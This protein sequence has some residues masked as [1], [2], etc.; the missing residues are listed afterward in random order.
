M[1]I[2]H[3]RGRRDYNVPRNRYHHW[4]YVW[5]PLATA[6]VWFGT[7]LALLITWLASGRPHYVSMSD[8]QT[9]AYISD[10]AADFLKPLFITGCAITAIGFVFCLAVERWARHEGRLL[11]DMR[12]REKV[13]GSLAIFWSFVGGVG[14]IL[15]SIFDTKRHSRLHRVFLLIFVV[16][17]ALSAIFTVIEFRWLDKTFGRR[18]RLLRIAYLIKA[19]FV[20]ILIV[21]A[22]AFGA[23][24]DSS[25]PND[26]AIIEWT[27]AFLFTVYLLTFWFDLRQSK[28]V[29]KGDLSP[30]RLVGNV[31]GTY[32]NM[33]AA[34]ECTGIFEI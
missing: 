17:T 29:E 31:N 3:P 20:F 8:D 18:F 23:L 24:L 13:M 12:R 11:P 30:E 2:S 27:I 34:L 14:L 25:S 26:G 28:G 22:I 16:G 1:N 19:I 32:G 9:I 33:H 10:V 4:L 6:F 15:L 7:V 5:V 21:L